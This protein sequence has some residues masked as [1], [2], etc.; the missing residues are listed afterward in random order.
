LEQTGRGRK[1]YVGRRCPED[2]QVDLGRADARGFE[3]TSGCVK[4]KITGRLAVGSLAALA[5]PRARA[6]PLVTGLD[7]LLEILIGND[8]F[9]QIAAGARDA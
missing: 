5:Y 4:R 9:R 1:D 3:G 8:L 6:N 2:N 7:E